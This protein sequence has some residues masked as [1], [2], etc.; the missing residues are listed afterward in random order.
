MLELQQ[1]LTPTASKS[2]INHVKSFLTSPKKEGFQKTV[3][4]S[5]GLRLI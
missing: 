5:A 1:N 2:V 4:F 3:T